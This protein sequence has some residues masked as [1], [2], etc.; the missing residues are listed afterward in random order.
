MEEITEKDAER[1]A[2]ACAQGIIS[3]LNEL[4]AQ[5][6]KIEK[7]EQLD[8]TGVEHTFTS[9]FVRVIGDRYIIMPDH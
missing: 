7:E 4:N 8:L 5:V 6:A 1:R 9:I 2:H 3:K